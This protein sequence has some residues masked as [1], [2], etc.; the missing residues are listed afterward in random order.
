MQA[1]LYLSLNVNKITWGCLA[2][3]GKRVHPTGFPLGKLHTPLAVLG[4]GMK[5][6]YAQVLEFIKYLQSTVLKN[7]KSYA[8]CA[9]FRM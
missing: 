5:D 1:F 2:S 7:L 3:A 4:S 9:L 8:V 6:Q